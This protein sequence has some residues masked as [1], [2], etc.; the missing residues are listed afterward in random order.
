MTHPLVTLHP[1][2]G[3]ALAAGLALIAGCSELWT[4]PPFPSAAPP[5]GFAVTVTVPAWGS[6]A[7]T[8]HNDTL[9]AVRA[10]GA[11]PDSTATTRV[12]RDSTAWQ[13]F[14]RSADAAGLRAWPALCGSR[15]SAQG[16]SYDVLVVYG[17]SL[18]VRSL[19][20]NSYPRRDGTCDRAGATA[21]FQALMAAVG[22]LIGQ[23]YP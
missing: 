15:D 14:W 6:H 20:L 12:V 2:R 9:V 7:V 13:A 22:A 17:D 5:V 1:L 19:G 11:K 10:F 18:H 23:T 3:L 4:A 8:L 16:P 21:E